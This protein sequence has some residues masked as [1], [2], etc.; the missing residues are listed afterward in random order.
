MPEAN[1]RV[2]VIVL[3]GLRPDV[4]AAEPT[5]NI[6]RLA[7]RGTWF[8][9]A[10]SV[11]PSMTRVASA[12]I[13][14]GAMP[15]LHGII[16]NAFYIP[17]AT[18]S[19]LIDGSYPED[20]DL[21]ETATGGRYVTAETFAD[22]LAAAGKS[23]AMVHAASAGCM[24]MLEPKRGQNCHWA[25]SLHGDGRE[26]SF[27]ASAADT[28][29]ERF[30]PLPEKQIP[31]FEEVDYATR[32]LTEYALPELKA[33]V[34]LIW[35][36]EPDYVFHYRSLRSGITT[37]VLAH[38]DSAVGRILDWVEAQPDAE[39]YNIILASDHGH[40][41]ISEE[42][43]LFGKLNAAGH[44][45]RHMRHR[46]LAD[47]D[48]AL[49]GWNM[50]EIRV[51]D[52]DR[53]RVD[54]IVALLRDDPAIGNIFTRG[55]VEGELPGT[56]GLGLVGLDH[57]RQPDIVYTMR[58]TDAPDRFGLPGHGPV[59]R[60]VNA[61]L[62]GSM[63]GGLNR[64]ELNTTLIAAGTRFQRNAVDNRP[65]GIIDIAPTLLD[66][67]GVPAASS[68]QGHS[69]ANHQRPEATIRHYEIGHG[70][71]SQSVVRAERPGAAYLQ[72]GARLA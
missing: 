29:L 61:P 22:R 4:I 50:G 63:H 52:G 27:P 53:R 9:E 46:S 54:N 41:T 59:V 45:A 5:P 30:G 35:V 17:E 47:C 6:R 67:V 32:V 72:S 60:G 55:A 8:R 18:T 13:A 7:A 37:A 58:S 38:V 16:G 51:L 69:L 34:S 70:A 10:R 25:F 33:D 21:A 44:R 12:S 24:H 68:M 65:A 62:W 19:R 15:A 23:F 66:L 28:V 31:R 40:I 11:F 14:T 3:D 20:I 43:D 36:S 42:A 64:S 1:A 48:I 49:T 2:I 71:Y 57:A 39:D 56:F 26:R